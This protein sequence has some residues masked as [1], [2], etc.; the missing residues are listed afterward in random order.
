[1]LIPSQIRRPNALGYALVA[2]V[3]VSLGVLSSAYVYTQ[4]DQSGREHI[5]DRAQTVAEM[6]PKADIEEL[7]GASYDLG[8]PAYARVKNTLT[9]IRQVNS[10]VRFAYLVGTHSNGNIFF[11][12]DSENPSS[13][14]YSPPGQEYEEASPAMHDMFETGVPVTEGPD[15]DRWGVWIS[16]YAPVRDDSGKIIALL[17]LDLPAS[18]YVTDVVA[19]SLLP[20]L[21]ALLL[22]VLITAA[23]RMHAREY[24]SIA[25]KAEF[26]SIASHE[27]RTPLTGIRWAVESM[28]S[29]RTNPVAGELRTTL[30]RVHEG[31]LMLIA[32]INNLLDVTAFESR[33]VS[34]LKKS[35][36]DIPSFVHE[37]V[38]SLELSA[39]QREV[40]IVIDPSVE[41]AG[42]FRAD[43]QTMHH[44]FF[45]LMA[46]AVK[47]TNPN[48]EV[49]I[50]YERSPRMH[51]FC[52]V[53]QGPGMSA[54]DQAHI[55][56]GYH[57]TEAAVRSGQYGSGLGLYLA[58][59]AAELH[60]GSVNVMSTLGE[61]AR[62]TLTIPG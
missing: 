39:M 14:D 61:G 4:I 49:R 15:R 30:E 22:L 62:F 40:R 50:A 32:R 27:I 26:L 6:F 18:Q 19:Y 47:Y 1:M 2:L 29:S 34:V 20:L 45:N 37:I 8:T 12:A 52:F 36:I 5:K 42:V 51:V 44:V 13:Q 58:R 54:H 10:D 28:L 33:G 31:C 21:V 24:R 11:F 25:Q 38:E 17:G 9:R 55:F 43:P 56:E 41:E 7:A 46:N 57:R 3:I 35:D 48:T 60:G 16:A 59:T 53:D 23:E